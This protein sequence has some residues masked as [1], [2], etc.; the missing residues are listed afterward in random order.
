MKVVV[1]GAMAYA[2]PIM[3]TARIRVLGW[4]ETVDAISAVRSV[5][6]HVDGQQGLGNAWC[7]SRSALE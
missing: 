4:S 2:V 7:R 3:D 1:L 5:L 6:D